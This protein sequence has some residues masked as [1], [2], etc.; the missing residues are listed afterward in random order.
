MTDVDYERITG[1]VPYLCIEDDSE[2]AAIARLRTEHPLVQVAFV[3]HMFARVTGTWTDV[4]RFVLAEYDG[5]EA[6]QALGVLA[7]FQ[8]LVETL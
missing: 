1:E 5:C 8:P 4:L 2:Q 7:A 6:D 3:G